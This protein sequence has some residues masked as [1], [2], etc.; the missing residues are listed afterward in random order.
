MR[1]LTAAVLCLAALLLTTILPTH[2]INTTTPSSSPSSPCEPAACGVLRIAYPFWLGGTHPP[3]CG[4]RAFQVTCDANGTAALTNSFWTYH[5]LHISYNDS[6]FTVAN[7]DLGACDVERLRVNAS[8]DLGLAPFGISAT[9][10]ELF[11]LY[12][13]SADTLGSPPPAW[14]PVNCTD[15]LGANNVSAMS[16]SFAWLAGGYRPDD[17]WRP[18][19]GNCTVSMMPVLGYDGAAGKDYRRLMKGGFLLD[20]AAGDCAACSAGS[21]PPTISSSATAPTAC[22]TSSSSVTVIKLDLAA[23]YI[24]SWFRN[25]IT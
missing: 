11:F 3:E 25:I 5:I 15:G 14:A 2:S 19:E 7:A 13:C 16:S 6:S 1:P 17:V 22:P 23:F 4:Y 12:D 10:Q 21:T 24:L 8:S 9:N 20:Y 18:V